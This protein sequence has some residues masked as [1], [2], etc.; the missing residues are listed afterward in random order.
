MIY[1]V[2]KFHPTSENYLIRIKTPKWVIDN[3]KEFLEWCDQY[4]I[5]VGDRSTPSELVCLKEEDVVMFKLR[6][7]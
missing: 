2:Y 3:R 5:V 1:E 4:D 6:W 7:E